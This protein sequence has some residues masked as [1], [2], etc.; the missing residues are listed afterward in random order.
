MQPARA[1]F[2]GEGIETTLSV[3]QALMAAGSPL[4]R[5]AAFRAAID[6]DN[7]AGPAMGRVRHPTDVRINSRGVEMP[8]LVAN[9]EPRDDPAFR[10]IHVPET[11]RELYLLGDGD[12]EPV[13]TRLALERAAKRFAALYPWLAIR[14]AWATPGM[15]FNDMWIKHHPEKCEALFGTDDAAK[16]HHPEKCEALFGSD[17]AV[18]KTQPEGVA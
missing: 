2:L 10:P 15:D 18:K 8:A 4:L 1:L 12:S 6:L 3:W 13:F 5:G 9:G 11:I 17:D 14:I 7:L 16:K